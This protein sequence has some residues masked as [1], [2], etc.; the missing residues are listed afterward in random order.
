MVVTAL[1]SEGIGQKGTD[2]YDGG[3]KK[4]FFFIKELTEKPD[5]LRTRYPYFC[6]SA[7]SIGLS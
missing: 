6:Y 3:L 5:K 1:C 7:Y 2:Q 4:S